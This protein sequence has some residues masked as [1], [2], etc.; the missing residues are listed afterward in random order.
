MSTPTAF[1]KMIIAVLRDWVPA[2][3]AAAITL[4][5]VAVERFVISRLRKI[6]RSESRFR[7]QVWTIAILFVGIMTVVFLLPD[8]TNQDLALGVFGL[9]V[10]GALA[11]SSQS[12]IANG[13]A[14][15]MVR[16]LSS[17]KPGDFIEVDGNLGRVSELGLF[18][19][20]IQTSD[21]DLTTIPNALLMNRP[22]KVVRASGTIV[23][24]QVSIGYDTSRHKLEKLFVAAGAAAGLQEPFVQVV[25]LGDYSV[26]YRVAGFLP[27]PSRLLAARS[28]LRGAILDTLSGAGVEIM[29]PMFLAKREVT[30][31]PLLP[32][33]LVASDAPQFRRTSEDRVFDKAELASEIENQRRLAVEAQ[34][35]ISEIKSAMSE[36]N[37]KEREEAQARIAAHER[38][39]SALDY[40][41]EHL[42]ALHAAE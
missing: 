27:E 24:A 4:A 28:N 1:T 22:V 21:R 9:V 42:E 15:L 26:L 39:L 6:D 25:D 18:H 10:T 7:K 16:S 8:S 38:R 2:E 33:P 41:I 12:I 14:G 36:L 34:D 32:L 31:E 40:R 3:I 5:A 30:E 19:T 29:S 37:H 13:M 17:F 23:S 11:I 20:E 35:A